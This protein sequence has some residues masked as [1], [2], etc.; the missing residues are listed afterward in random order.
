M[1]SGV[2]TMR[3][4]CE[5]C[6]LHFEREEGYWT[7]AMLINWLLVTLTL[8]PIWVVMLLNGAPFPLTLLITLVLILLLLPLFFRYS[9]VIWLYLDHTVDTGEE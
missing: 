1:F 9:R 7:G 4:E 2:M 6:R 3:T 8:G 5:V